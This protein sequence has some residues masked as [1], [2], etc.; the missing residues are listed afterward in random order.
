MQAAAKEQI[1]PVMRIP[2]AAKLPLAQGR[3]SVYDQYCEAEWSWKSGLCPEI[4]MGNSNFAEDPLA[5]RELIRRVAGRDR[6][7]FETLYVRYA[8]RVFR[9]LSSQIQQREIVEETL[10]DVMMVVWETAARYNGTSQLS[11]WILGIAHFK[12]LKARTR[13]AK[14]NDEFKES[15]HGGVESRGPEEV[16]AGQELMDKILQALE[17]FS[18]EQRAVIELAF[19]HD[20]SYAEIAEILDCPVNTVKTR[21]FHARQRLETLFN[22]NQSRIERHR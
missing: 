16:I 5:D 2:C 12:A 10:D 21:M 19:Y 13:A 22:E 14:V 1:E 3:S 9:Y 15:E 18:A 17:N 7:A 4:S 6:E 8:P 20:R 11:T